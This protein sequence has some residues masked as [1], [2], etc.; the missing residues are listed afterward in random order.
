MEFCYARVYE[1]GI[2]GDRGYNGEVFFFDSIQEAKTQ[3]RNLMQKVMPLEEWKEWTDEDGDYEDF[4]DD[5][6]VCEYEI[7]VVLKQDFNPKF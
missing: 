6:E 7:C 5:C 4:L 3:M 2:L 1:D